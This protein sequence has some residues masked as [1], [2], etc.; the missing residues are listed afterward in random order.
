M[1]YKEFAQR[2]KTKYPEYADVDDKELSQRIIAKYPEYSDVTFDEPTPQGQNNQYF[3]R[4]NLPNVVSDFARPV[5]EVGGAVG[6]GVAG[7]ASPVPGGA[8]MGGAAGYAGGKAAADLLDRQLGVKAPLRSFPE[9]VRETGDNVRQGMEA[10][11]AGQAI[12]KFAPPVIEGGLGLVKKGAKKVLPSV[13]KTTAGIPEKATE[14]VIDNPELLKRGKITEDQLNEAA[15]PIIDGLRR[16]KQRVGE[17]FGKVF[18]KYTGLDN[19]IDEFINDLPENKAVMGKREGRVYVKEG[20]PL[21]DEFGNPL[22]DYIPPPPGTPKTKSFSYKEPVGT[23]PYREPKKNLDDLKI[24]YHAAK[25]G[26]LFKK[27]N[28]KTGGIEP[29]T[30]QEKLAKL[31]T[32]KRELQAEANSNLNGV[33]LKPIDTVVDAS[34]KKMAGEIDEIR[35]SLPNGKRLAVMDEA[36]QEIRDIYAKVQKDFSDPGKARDT[37]MRIMRGESNWMTSGKNAIKVNAIR[38]AERITGEDLLKPAMEELA[39]AIYQAPVGFGIKPAIFAPA[40]A[41]SAIND[42]F[43]GKFGQAAAQAMATGLASPKAI[44][45]GLRAGSGTSKILKG[46][47]SVLAKRGVGLGLASAIKSK[48]KD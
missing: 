42:F 39:A 23:K 29:M 36:W 14:A 17:K 35:G 12:S 26:S 37:L 40:V 5:L 9:A 20:H 25:D 46:G 38:R 3:S 13:F 21:V 11:L 43:N 4:E 34:I 18:K 7:F 1:N 8:A 2:V 47:S 45:L 19:P 30:N 31:T 22:P 24:D 28:P 6:G 10:E 27:T 33:T 32:L 16:A 48:R 44:S 15:N 41:G